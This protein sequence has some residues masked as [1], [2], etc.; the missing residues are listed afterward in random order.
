M[1]N[2]TKHAEDILSCSEDD[3]ASI[4][5]EI[6]SI[7]TEMEKKLQ[8]VGVTESLSRIAFNI[9]L[10]FASANKVNYFYF[11]LII[12]LI[13]VVLEGSRFSGLGW[14]Y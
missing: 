14:F 4:A 6:D 1:D 3:T 11:C 12:L 7:T 10:L 2:F 13:I 8:K 5:H 9:G